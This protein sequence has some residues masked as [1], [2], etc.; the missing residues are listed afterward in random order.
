MMTKHCGASAAAAREDD[1]QLG[2]DQKCY[3]YDESGQLSDARVDDEVW[4][5]ATCQH[6]ND[7]ERRSTACA[8]GDTLDC[9]CRNGPPPSPPPPVSQWFTSFTSGAGCEAN[10]AGSITTLADCSAAAAALG[11]D[12]TAE[13][14][15][16]DESWSPPYARERRRRRLAPVQLGGHEHRRLLERRHVHLLHRAAAAAV[17]AAAA[18]VAASPGPECSVARG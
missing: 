1:V 13:D 17:V 7:G 11:L 2:H 15:G 3:E 4:K 16:R 8:Y 6:E 9:P 5:P 14:D 12:T 10:G 18:A